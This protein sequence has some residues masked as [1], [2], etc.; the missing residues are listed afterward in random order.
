MIT[1]YV[2]LGTF[3]L[4]GALVALAVYQA[5]RRGRSEAREAS[6]KNILEKIDE[7]KKARQDVGA[8][9]PDARREWLSKWT[10]R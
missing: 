10:R 4:T 5:R 1:L 9:T 7:A 3:G 8:L 6:T 2:L